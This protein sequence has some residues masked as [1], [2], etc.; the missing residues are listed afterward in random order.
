[1]SQLDLLIQL[2][3]VINLLLDAGP[4]GFEGGMSTKKYENIA[5]TSRAT[6]SR[7]LIDLEAMGLLERVGGGR[8]TRYYPKLRGW[9]LPTTN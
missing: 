6:A 8:S 3:K 9:E 5:A 7:E 1:M 2:T 4:S